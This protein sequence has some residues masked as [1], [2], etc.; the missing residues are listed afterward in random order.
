MTNKA[1]AEAVGICETYA[2]TLWQTYQRGGM[3][4]LEPNVRGR[5]YGE[6][7]RLTAEQEAAIQKILVDKTPDQLKFPF[8]LWTR[9]AI[10]L[11]LSRQFR[12]DLPLRTITYYLK[13]WGFT[14]QRPVK[15]AYEQNP[16]KVAHWLDTD[17]R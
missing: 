16:A 5:R 2:S 11:L 17:P 9:D 13:R 6:K 1:A 15:R 7:R 14:P 12:I 8:A 3:K 10:R 4:A